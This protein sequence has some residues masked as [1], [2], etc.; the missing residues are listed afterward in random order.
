MKTAF[1]HA[2][3]PYIVAFLA[4]P[5]SAL[6]ENEPMAEAPFEITLDIDND[7]QM[8][9]AVMV[10]DPDNGQADLYVYLAAGDEKLDP[11]R[12]PT[13]IKK[14]LTDG[15]VLELESKGKGSLSVT[16]CFGCG[17]NKSWEET[18]TIVHRGAE[19]LVAGY[20]RNWDWN[21]QTSDGDVETTLGSCDINF[22]TGKG[23]ASQGLDDGE[24]IEEKF[25][26]MNL[27]DWSN[28]SRP[29]SCDF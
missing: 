9:R 24:P 3:L 28:D 22:L 13:F 4:I 14:A 6:A 12:K 21:V 15:Q 17:A 25:T 5:M 23:I 2:A 26:P 8:D 1:H 20:S 19:F 18:L 29:K 10:Q 11:S 27:A 7:G 16:S